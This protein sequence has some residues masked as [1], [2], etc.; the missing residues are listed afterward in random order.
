M[1]LD[2]G[3]ILELIARD[4]EEHDLRSSGMGI[5]P[6]PGANTQPDSAEPAVE[7][8]IKDSLWLVDPVTI[9]IGRF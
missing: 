9:L 8:L 2:A 3:V 6:W 7:R 4:M 1:E 5:A